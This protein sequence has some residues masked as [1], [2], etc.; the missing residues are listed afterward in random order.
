MTIKIPEMTGLAAVTTQ[1]TSRWLF[2]A[3]GDAD[4][5]AGLARELRLP[6]AAAR[7]LWQRGFRNPA[8]AHSFLNPRIEDLHDPFL[9]RD[10]DRAVARIRAAIARTG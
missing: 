5:I 3:A 2:P 1:K 4:V 7:I 9:L 6:N 10:M 8:D